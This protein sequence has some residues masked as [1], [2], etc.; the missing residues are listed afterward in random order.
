MWLT[1]CESGRNRGG[2][3]DT[4]KRFIYIHGTPDTEPMGKPLSHGCIR[5]T[6]TDIMEL[7]DL[8]DNEMPVI[9]QE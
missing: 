6:N 5:M 9:I 8:V 2:A 7:F 1:G 4:L 3:T